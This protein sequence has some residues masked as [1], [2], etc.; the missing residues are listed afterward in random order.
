MSQRQ[1]VVVI[2]DQMTGLPVDGTKQEHHVIDIHGIMTEMERYDGNNFPMTCQQCQ[3]LLNR[4]FVHAMLEK[5]F[6]IL[7]QSV[8]AE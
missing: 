7:S 4:S 3:E 8:E 1:K 5:L 6:C 2:A